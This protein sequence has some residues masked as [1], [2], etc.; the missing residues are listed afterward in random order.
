MSWAELSCYL[1]QVSTATWRLGLSL[2]ISSPAMSFT[3]TSRAATLPIVHREELPL[4]WSKGCLFSHCPLKIKY[5]LFMQKLLWEGWG[6]PV[7]NFALLSTGLGCSK[8]SIQAKSAQHAQSLIPTLVE[9]KSSSFL[10]LYPLK[11][12][13]WLK[14]H[15]LTNI[16]LTFQFRFMKICFPV[17]HP[18]HTSSVLMS[19]TDMG[20][21]CM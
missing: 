1:V 8:S 14:A 19:Y 12:H 9:K 11:N 2:L 21:L 18:V 17:I 6:W 5:P 3:G 20:S 10:S 13:I 15:T 16:F 7:V 4:K